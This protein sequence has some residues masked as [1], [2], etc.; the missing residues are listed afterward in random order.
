MVLLYYGQ[1]KEETVYSIDVYSLDEQFLPAP[2]KWQRIGSSLTVLP[3]YRAL[4]GIWGRHP[5]PHYLS[6]IKTFSVC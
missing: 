3:S 6:L 1:I 5:V 2:R 4:W